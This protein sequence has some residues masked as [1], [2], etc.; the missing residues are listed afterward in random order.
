MNSI[1]CD[2][3][4]SLAIWVWMRPMIIMRSLVRTNPARS[5]TMS[6]VKRTI[7]G[8]IVAEA[9]KMRHQANEKPS[10][11]G[12]DSKTQVGISLEDLYNG[13]TVDISI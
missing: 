5:P 10:K 2:P 4:L 12:K 8:E 11:K 6:D 13:N 9:T 7:S 3:I 1:V